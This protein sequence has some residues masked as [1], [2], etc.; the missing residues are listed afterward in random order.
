MPP[1]TKTLF[2]TTGGR[3]RQKILECKTNPVKSY[4]EYVNQLRRR[5]PD[6]W[7]ALFS[8]GSHFTSLDS[9]DLVSRVNSRPNDW[10]IG[11]YPPSKMRDHLQGPPPPH[12]LLGVGAVVLRGDQVLL[13]KA[14]YRN[15][16][17]IPSGYVEIG[18]SLIEAIQREVYEETRIRI[19]AP[20]LFGI[21]H[22]APKERL[23]D[24]YVVFLSRSARGSPEPDGHETTDARF[25]SF[26][27]LQKAADVSSFSK[28]LV[29]EAYLFLPKHPGLALS[30]WKPQD[31]GTTHKAYSV[32]C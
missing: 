10:P 16:W 26:R 11:I 15:V 18:E 27:E 30:K 5:Q 6:H 29:R 19:R 23:T 28:F 24:T 2:Y 7:V 4:I 12:T 3:F 20:R 32:F 22:S 25:F 17:I 9:S 1:S 8:D 14:S 31:V 13:T 21:R